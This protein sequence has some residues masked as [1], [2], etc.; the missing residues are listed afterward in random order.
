A[1]LMERVYG[2]PVKFN[3]NL[4]LMYNSP[5]AA[6]DQLVVDHNREPQALYNDLMTH[7]SETKAPPRY[8]RYCGATEI[9]TILCK[10]GSMKS[11]HYRVGKDIKEVREALHGW[12]ETAHQILNS[13]PSEVV[14][15]YAS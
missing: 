2:A 4:G 11:G 6:L 3:P 13:M 12:G 8:D 5:R 10:W 14:V 1:D 9:E 7:F 15:I